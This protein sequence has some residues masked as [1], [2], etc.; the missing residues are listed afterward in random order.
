MMLQALDKQVVA[1]VGEGIFINKCK[2]I[3]DYVPCD[4]LKK[5]DK[6]P[7]LKELFF[8]EWEDQTHN[9]HK[10]GHYLVQLGGDQCYAG[11]EHRKVGPG[12]LGDES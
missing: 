6:L 12:R 7:N 3:F 4:I 2:L 5:K 10:I 11:K 8:S 9:T 1:A